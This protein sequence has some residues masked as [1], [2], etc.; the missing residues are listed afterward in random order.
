MGAQSV[1][2]RKTRTAAAAEAAAAQVAEAEGAQVAE[3]AG[4]AKEAADA[5]PDELC[6]RDSAPCEGGSG[7]G[8]RGQGDGDKGSVQRK[9]TSEAT[10][11]HV[12]Q[13]Q[14]SLEGDLLQY[15]FMTM[16]SCD[17]AD[18]ALAC[19]CS[20]WRRVWRDLPNRAPCPGEPA[21]CI[22]GVRVVARV[23]DVNHRSCSFSLTW[24]WPT[25]KVAVHLLE[26]PSLGI[27][28]QSVWKEAAEYGDKPGMAEYR[29]HAWE[30]RQHS[31][32]VDRDDEGRMAA[33]YVVESRD[34]CLG[35][36]TSGVLEPL[37]AMAKD[38]RLKP[39]VTPLLRRASRR[40]RTCAVAA[41][42]RTPENQRPIPANKVTS[43]YLIG[44]SNPLEV[45]MPFYRVSNFRFGWPLRFTIPL[46]GDIDLLECG[47]SSH[48]QGCPVQPFCNGSPAVLLRSKVLDRLLQLQQESPH[49]AMEQLGIRRSEGESGAV[50]GSCAGADGNGSDSGGGVGCVDGAER[51]SDSVGADDTP[52]PTEVMAV[53]EEAA[54]KLPQGTRRSEALRGG[55]SIEDAAAVEHG[56]EWPG[57][58]DA[59]PEVDERDLAAEV[60]ERDM[61]AEEKFGYEQRIARAGLRREIIL[62]T[63]QQQ[64]W[65]LAHKPHCVRCSPGLT[66]PPYPGP[67]LVY[68]HNQPIPNQLI[69]S[70][71]T[72]V[73]AGQEFM[74]STG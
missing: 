34:P 64:V 35:K 48:L 67:P 6:R 33:V 62:F 45:G 49:N 65:N 4:A 24:G 13:Q 56:G 22:D 1:E 43:L 30:D 66:P 41:S 63:Q 70:H 23:S 28:L 5:A 15:L 55:D 52:S 51:A 26:L 20:L 18:P 3:A 25:M 47:W 12:G 31:R 32:S 58:D 21:A 7:A 14:L 54:A 42:G 68:P 11:A 60:D 59:A 16:A 19:V 40:A 53:A 9:S 37:Q 50:G 61:A 8:G 27:A 44:A 74:H 10:P 29:D 73:C 38:E 72:D 69:A 46:G 36:Y 57:T 17:L 2:P 39:I 71:R